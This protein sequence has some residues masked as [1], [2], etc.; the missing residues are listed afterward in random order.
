MHELVSRR[1]ESDAAAVTI[2]TMHAAKGLQFPCVVVADLWKPAEA[3]QR[4]QARPAVFYAEDG[5]R[6]VDL[7]HAVSQPLGH[8]RQRQQAAENEEARRLLYVAATRAEHY[9]GI[10]VPSDDS[11]SILHQTITLPDDLLPADQLP[12][13]L[14]RSLP[15]EAEADQSLDLAALPT[16]GRTERRMSFTGLVALRGRDDPY[17]PEGGGY[18]EPVQPGTSR[19]TFPGAIDTSD[20]AVIDLP[21][22]VAVGRIVH[23]VFERVDPTADPLEDEVR[24]VVQQRAVTGRLKHAQENLVAMVCETLRTPLGG[25]F[26]SLTLAAVPPDQRLPEL[27][28]EMGLASLTAGVRARSIGRL[29]T[30]FL[31]ADDVLAGYAAT[32]A[33]PAFDLPVGGL[34]T[35]SID[36][37]LGLP[38]SQPE[39]PRLAICDYKS[40]RLHASGASDPL[41]AYT[42]DRLV[43][44]MAEHHY[45]LQALLY[46]TAVTR[47]LRWRLPAVDPDDCLVGVVYAF[48][49][50]MKGPTTPH[51]ASGQRCGVFVW[52]PPRGLWRALSDLLVH[53][54]VEEVSA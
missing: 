20:H 50:G 39:Q 14:I 45:P 18:D 26:G 33:G 41:Q 25:P 30:E 29:L 42:P 17:A 51:D 23:E 3:K 52:K 11:P 5:R 35:G 7:G 27:D 28:F 13:R 43:A 6:Y 12:Q 38:E 9:L 44:A 31:P 21:A 16:V 40:N 47:L 48:I 1:V 53:R 46:G 36:A 8:A 54:R 4:G 10:V 15:L 49:R 2:L 32:L 34:L 24:R 37:L 19:P 22:G